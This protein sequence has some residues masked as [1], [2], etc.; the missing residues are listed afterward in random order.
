MPELAHGDEDFFLLASFSP[1]L[2]RA[3]ICRFFQFLNP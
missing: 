2:S 3:K 1:P